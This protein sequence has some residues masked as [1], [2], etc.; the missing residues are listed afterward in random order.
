VVVVCSYTGG[1]KGPERLTGDGMRYH[2]GMPRE[3]SR[4]GV[5]RRGL[6]WLLTRRGC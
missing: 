3:A 5:G 6:G 4:W 2:E 1:G